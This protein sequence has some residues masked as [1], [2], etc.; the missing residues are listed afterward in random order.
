MGAAMRH[1]KAKS[2]KGALKI[3]LSVAALGTT[4]KDKG[5]PFRLS[6]R[7]RRHRRHRCRRLCFH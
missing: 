5:R 7:R 1:K 6:D 2:Q 3:P 4:E